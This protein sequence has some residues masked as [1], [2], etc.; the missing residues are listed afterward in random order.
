MARP[1]GGSAVAVLFTCTSFTGAGLL[2]LVQPMVAKLLLPLFGG[3]PSVWNTSN[4]FFQISLLSGYLLTHLT[5]RRLGLRRQPLLQV[6]IVLLP[7]LVLPIGLPTRT[8]TPEGTAPV[9]WLLAVLVLTVGAPFL[10]LS[11]A[12]PLL[13]RW[14]GGTR[15]PRAQEPYFLFAAGNTGS[16]LALLSYP[17]LVEPRLTLADQL[18]W[19]SL[20]YVVFAVLI[21][22]CALVLRLYG[23][24]TGEVAASVPA[25]ERAVVPRRRRLHWVALAALPSSFMLGTTT[26]LS[27]DLTPVPL[28]WVVPLSL[29]LVTFIVAFALSREAASRLAQRVALLLPALVVPVMLGATGSPLPLLAQVLSHTALFT[30]VALVAH[31]R[32][33]AD[34]PD[35]AGL[36][37]FYLLLAVGG[38]LGGSVN[39]LLAPVLL[40]KLYEYP[41]AIALAVLLVPVSSRRRTWLQRRYGVLGTLF[42]V[43]A[44]AA[45]LPAARLLVDLPGLQQGFLFAVVVIV[46]MVTLGR[47]GSRSPGAFAL[48][49]VL[50]LVL[51]LVLSRGLATTR[52]F[53]GVQEVTE[54]GGIHAL[55]HGSTIHGTQDLRPGR[56]GEP[57]SYYHRAGPAGQIFAVPAAVAADARLGFVGLG[58]GALAA[59]GRAGQEIT[60]FEIDRATADIARDPRLFRYL[61]GTA[62]EVDIVL[63]DG[64]LSLAAE[65]TAAYDVLVLDAF[66]SDAIPVHLV[67]QEAVGLYVSRLAQDGVLAFHI[68]NRYI[69]L[70][71]V[72]ADIADVLGLRGVVRYDA[73]HDASSGKLSSRWI[74]LS[75][76]ERALSTLTVDPRWEDLAAFRRGNRAWSDDFSNVLG[77]LR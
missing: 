14:F 56:A 58:T 64:R 77:A 55:R 8:A 52:T 9:L 7:L 29:Y 68:S 31:A 30:A 16:L 32:L 2:F 37:G 23:G 5:V 45:S 46:L 73:E 26:Y 42:L 22:C 11:T 53:F 43:V 34:R 3:S 44:C 41:V 28:L 74:A 20:G 15:H 10:V 63:G 76:D 72:L 57:R 75:R 40:D 61:S 19:W 38:A 24:R 6:G 17:V 27:T 66:S 18:R 71:P 47:V 49:L 12:G 36:T 70:A 25:P 4:L 33:S 48:G 67:T 51:P 39:A 50:V 13:Q 59:Y 54:R 1:H 35:V 60:F 65:P 21:I 69:D 62:A